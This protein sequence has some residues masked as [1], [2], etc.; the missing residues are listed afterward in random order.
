M[1]GQGTFHPPCHIL[2]YH[3]LPRPKGNSHNKTKN[4]N[5]VQKDGMSVMQEHTRVS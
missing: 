1:R 2:H 5:N 4:V 3:M